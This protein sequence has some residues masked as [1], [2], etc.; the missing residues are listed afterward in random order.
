M[1]SIKPIASRIG[2]NQISQINHVK[3]LDYL[4]EVQDI[5]D[6]PLFQNLDYYSQHGD[7]SRRQHSINVSY[8]SYRLCRFLRLD[9][10]SAARAGLLHD[11]FFYRWQDKKAENSDFKHVYEHP[12]DALDN[13]KR[14]CDLSKLESDIITKHMFPFCYG[15]P[16]YAETFVVSLV[17]KLSATA[18][19]LVFI[20][21]R[22]KKG[23]RLVARY[24]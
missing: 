18:E 16:R 2:L 4:N 7:I 3:A 21:S 9:A 17:D 22:F 12:F 24:F 10:R 14:V 11:L 23:A 1:I 8:H 15:M 20:A 19:A 13:A 5:L 6:H